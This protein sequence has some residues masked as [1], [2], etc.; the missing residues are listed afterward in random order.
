MDLLHKELSRD[1]A[2]NPL[3]GR[4]VGPGVLVS[5]KFVYLDESGNFDFRLRQDASSYFAIGSAIFDT[6][7]DVVYAETAMHALHRQLMWEGLTVGDGF[8]AQPDSPLIRGRVFALLPSM[9]FRFDVTVLDKRKAQPKLRTTDETFYK[10]AMYYHL[11]HVLR[12][13]LSDGD[14]LVVVAASVGTS[15]KRKGF[16]QAVREVVEQCA[17]LNEW[18]AAAVRDDALPGLQV[19]DYCLWGIMRDL[20]QGDPSYRDRVP[21]KASE[22]QLFERGSTLYY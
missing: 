17:Q 13:D 5:R 2:P 3:P 21:H 22:F 11:R 7:F 4:L 10:Y 14:E 16:H 9:N 1:D 19:A 12:R 18:R 15:K 8:H 20:E 6:E